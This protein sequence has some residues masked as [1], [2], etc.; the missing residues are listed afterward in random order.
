MFKHLTDF[1]TVRTTKEAFGFYIAYFL[2]FVIGGAVFGS[3]IA[4]I[5]GSANADLIQKILAPIL[6]AADGLIC[7]LIIKKKN[8]GFIYWLLS[9]VSCGLAVLGGGFLGLIIP[10]FMTT[11]KKEH[12]H[13]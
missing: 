3:T 12:A 1:G 5:A 2:L 8:L 6:F 4:V 11:L 7:F 9:V 13:T 10:A